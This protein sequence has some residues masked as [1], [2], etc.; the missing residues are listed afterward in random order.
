MKKCTSTSILIVLAILTSTFCLLFSAHAAD[1]EVVK[2]WKLIHD[3]DGK[4]GMKLQLE[5]TFTLSFDENNLIK[6]VRKGNQ[7]IS[8]DSPSIDKLGMF[9]INIS[10][11]I[12]ISQH[13]IKKDIWLEK[14]RE[15]KGIVLSAKYELKL[16]K[17]GLYQMTGRVFQITAYTLVF[18]W[19]YYDKTTEGF[20]SVYKKAMEKFLSENG[21]GGVCS[22]NGSHKTLEVLYTI[23]SDVSAKSA[24]KFLRNN[25]LLAEK[26][27]AG[28][29]Q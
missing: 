29:P 1:G 6:S 17:D 10:S 18:D 27:W 19:G 24:E 4:E 3:E 23:N 5:D 22:N 21:G 9:T 28:I 16:Q 12:S 25:Q 26:A 7:T 20:K 14:K 8:P 13:W 2:T 15:D 11:D